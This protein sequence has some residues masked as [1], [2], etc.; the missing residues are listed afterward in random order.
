MYIQ[1]ALWCR[2]KKKHTPSPRIR[3][4]KQAKEE[5]EKTLNAWI[6]TRMLGIIYSERLEDLTF[7]VLW[8]RQIRYVT[9]LAHTHTCNV[10]WCSPHSS[11]RKRLKTLNF[12]R[13][14]FFGSKLKM[15]NLKVEEELH[16]AAIQLANYSTTNFNLKL[17]SAN[18]PKHD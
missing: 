16:C 13:I 6:Y 4:E 8:W 1:C 12:V 15:Q 5:R 14:F 10:G 9:M 17:K 18:T 11:A 2:Y 7:W 3:W